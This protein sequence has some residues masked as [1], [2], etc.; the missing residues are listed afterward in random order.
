MTWSNNLYLR[1]AATAAIVL[2]MIVIGVRWIGRERQSEAASLL[3]S[4]PAAGEAELAREPQPAPMSTETAEPSEG[5]QAAAELIAVDVIG[6]VAAPGVYRLQPQSRVEDAVTAAGGLAPDAN[7]ERIN[8]AAPVEDGVQIRVPRADESVAAAPDEQAAG[9]AEAAAGGTVDIN[10]ADAA[11]LEALPG[12]GPATAA[13][14]VAHREANGPFQSV[15]DLQNVKGIGPSLFGKLAAL[16]S[17][18]T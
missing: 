15:E 7:R 4:A 18:G 10:T 8:L 1:W 5:E 2:L 12:V 16:V 17:V 14:I 11:A 3:A 9:P 6:A 13:A